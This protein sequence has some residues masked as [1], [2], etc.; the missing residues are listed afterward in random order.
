MRWFRKISK[1]LSSP[2]AGPSGRRNC[3]CARSVTRSRSPVVPRS[4]RSTVRQAHIVVRQNVPAISTNPQVSHPRR[5]RITSPSRSSD[6]T[7]PRHSMG[8]IGG[9]PTRPVRPQR[10]SSRSSNGSDIVS[11]LGRSPTRPVRSQRALSRS[12]NGSDISSSL[13]R[14]NHSDTSSVSS[15]SSP[16]PLVTSSNNS[17]NASSRGGSSND[18]DAT[19]SVVNSISLNDP[20]ATS[21]P[22]IPVQHMATTS[23]ET[24]AHSRVLRSRIIPRSCYW[25]YII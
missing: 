5:L 7:S 1:L 6:G 19:S 16:I 23:N 9:S 25:M 21:S 18:S 13:G 15:R 22:V 17:D 2:S 8:S 3:H 24:V 11:S 20:E 14:S 12:S 10:A 4:D